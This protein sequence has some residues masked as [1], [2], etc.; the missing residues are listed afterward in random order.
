MKHHRL[1]A[2]ERILKKLNDK[3]RVKIEEVWECFINREGGFLEDTRV[4]NRTEPPTMWFIAE[5][6]KG[7]QLKIV[8][9]KLDDGNY[10]IKTAYEHNV[11]EVKI[12]EKYS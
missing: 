3:H 12:Y 5:T 10:E 9:I 2:S 6:D 7:R 1:K 4:N 8:F 11:T